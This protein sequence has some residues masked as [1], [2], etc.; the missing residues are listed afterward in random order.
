M[1]KVARIDHPI[2]NRIMVGNVFTVEDQIK[3]KL[4]TKANI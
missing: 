3:A 1:A 4:D 2:L